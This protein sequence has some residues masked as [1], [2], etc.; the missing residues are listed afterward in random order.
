MKYDK[1]HMATAEAYANESQCPE[2]ML[3]VLSYWRQES[4]QV[5]STGM[6]VVAL[7]NGNSHLTGTQRLYTP[8]L[9]RWGSVWSRDSR[10]GGNDVCYSLTLPRMF[11][12]LGTC[13]GEKS[14]L[15]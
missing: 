3:A 4:C 9:I 11:E 15:S 12:T 6:R 8:N 13:R 10:Q 5:A 1:M 14:C 7:I 2:R